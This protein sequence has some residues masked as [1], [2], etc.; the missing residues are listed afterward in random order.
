ME[1]KKHTPYVELPVFQGP[2]D[3]LL[4][5]IQQNK[6]D[7]YDIPLAVIADQFI[8]SVRR[9]GELDMEITSEF[10]VLAAQLLYLKSR[11]LLPKPQ[12]TEEE[13]EQ[14]EGLKQDLI[15]RLVTYKAYKS[16]ATFLSG[17]ESATG[18]K[19]FRDVDMEEI[20][21]RFK[22][23]NPLQ[24]IELDDLFNAFHDI[25]TRVATGNDI[26]YVQIEE[27]PVDVMVTDI[28]RRLILAPSGMKFSQLLRYGSRIEI[29]VAFIA[30]LEL[31]KDGRIR[32]EQSDKGNDIYIVPTPK[33][34]DFTN[35]EKEENVISGH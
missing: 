26:Q 4:S 6:M 1:D 11:S 24:G 19:Y 20:L 9:M 3:L 10:L 7:I 13:I 14:E 27:I 12:K 21:A 29:V 8:S 22:P 2:L 25:L 23:Q 33:A 5:L 15:E 31:L 32:A 17:K 35:E 30:M 18:N 34:W 28:T 16:I